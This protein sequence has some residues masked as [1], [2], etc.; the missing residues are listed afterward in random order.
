MDL[1][2]FE[3]FLAIVDTKSIT[4]ASEKL[5]LS[6]STVSYRV[7][8]LEEELQTKLINREQ[9]QRVISLT[10][11]G[12]EFLKFAKKA[13]NIKKELENWKN[14]DANQTINIG[15]VDSL[16]IYILPKLYKS[17]IQKNINIKLNIS[18][19]WSL[20]ICNLVE[21]ND[22]DIGMVSILKESQDIIATP[23]F[24]EEMVVISNSDSI[25]NKIE[26]PKN[27]DAFYELKLD[28][29]KDF[30]IWHDYCF[31]PN[32]QTQ[33]KV[34]TSGLIFNLVC[35]K[36]SWA[37]VPLEVAQFYNE[38]RKIKISFLTDPPP[39]RTIYKIKNIYTRPSVKKNLDLF[40]E[41][42]ESFIINN[43]KLITP[44]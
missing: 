41:Y 21:L 23:I 3:I 28:W 11:K 31:G 9:G 22:I 25:Y 13:Y 34:D 18:S 24:R 40:E 37:I 33:L 32:I 39:S 1:F 42:L 16:N 12:E 8:K 35:G 36:K 29:G 15:A 5:F 38:T 10:L 20:K 19:H 30:Q 7:T 17:F 44:L 4:A 6:Q 26:N 14:K 27:L 43:S 2:D